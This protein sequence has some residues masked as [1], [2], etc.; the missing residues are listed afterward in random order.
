MLN[1]PW[2][3]GL[4]HTLRFE[5]DAPFPGSSHAERLAFAKRWYSTAPHQPPFDGWRVP[6]RFTHL[7]DR[8]IWMERFALFKWLVLPAQC[9]MA[10]F[11]ECNKY[12][13]L[14]TAVVR[15]NVVASRI[16][17]YTLL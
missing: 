1:P 2:L 16:I 7:P 14:R 5:F 3:S 8:F 4:L 6:A 10:R 17:L 11:E 9:M 12:D 13:L 15:N